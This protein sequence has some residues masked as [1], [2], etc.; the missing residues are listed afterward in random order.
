[1]L[2]MIEVQRQALDPLQ[3]GLA[4]REPGAARDECAERE[5]RGGD[6]SEHECRMAAEGEPAKQVGS[7][8]RRGGAT[9]APEQHR[10]P[11]RRRGD[12]HD[13]PGITARVPAGG[14]HVCGE[15]QRQKAAADDMCRLKGAVAAPQTTARTCRRSRRQHQDQDERRDS[16]EL[17]QR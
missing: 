5:Y 2:A 14:H 6:G 3:H 12:E 1:M 4:K 7:V 17:I 11:A 13:A 16:R 9:P 10:D 15:E 8:R